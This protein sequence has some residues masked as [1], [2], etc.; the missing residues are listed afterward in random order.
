MPRYSAIPDRF[1]EEE[2]RELESCRH[3]KGEEA[4]EKGVG[5]KRERM[6]ESERGGES[7]TGTS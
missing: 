7:C 6:R 2:R 5:V 3:T 4:R 1:G